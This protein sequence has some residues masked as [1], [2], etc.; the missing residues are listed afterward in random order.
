MPA[1]KTLLTA[2]LCALALFLLT[3][4]PASTAIAWFAPAEVGAFGVS[5]TVWS[6]KARLI[7]V[8]G[9]QFRN[10]EWNLRLP[11]L[12]LGRLGADFS[13]RWEGGF[14]EGYGATSLTGVIRLENMRGS[15]DIAALQGLFGIPKIGGIANIRFSEAVIQ[16]NWPHLLVGEG[17]LRSLSSP[18]MGSGEAQFIGDI[19]FNFDTATETDT[20]T[21][22]G[23]L[24]DAGGPLQLSGT[25]ILTPPSNYALKTKVSARE[26]APAA[27]RKN[28]TFLGAADADGTR[29]F[30][31]S[32]SL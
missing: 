11:G 25:L 27:L 32:G 14:I 6:G 22:T 5:G 26:N 19:A 21:I 10:T 17:E 20:G 29:Q 16:D 28:L 8:A 4:F 1:N 7:S 9:L 15:F 24:E 31:L 18:L 23:R 13:S 12:L 30:E 2:G 3:Q